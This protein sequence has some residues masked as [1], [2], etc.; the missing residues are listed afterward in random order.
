MYVESPPSFA[1]SAL[2]EEAWTKF[3]QQ[4]PALMSWLQRVGQYY[5]YWT[6]VKRRA[7]KGGLSESDAWML[8][9]IVRQ[10][11]LRKLKLSD[12]PSFTFSFQ[13][14][15]STLEKLHRFDLYLGGMLRSDSLIP[16]EDKNRY[17]VSSIMEEAIASSQLEGASTTREVAKEMLRK[18]RPPR[19]KSEQMILNN[20]RTIQFV[21]AR[22]QAPM[23]PELL[24]Q[25][26]EQ[27]T[28]GTLRDEAHAGHIRLT[29][30]V[31]VWNEVAGE[32]VY[33]PPPATQLPELLKVFCTFANEELASSSNQA[34]L[35]IHPIVRA[36]ILHFLIGYIHPFIDGNGRTARAVF[37]WYLLRQGYWLVEYMSISRIIHESAIQYAKAY[38]HTENDAN[39]LTYFINY[40]VKT[41]NQAFDS[42]QQYIGRKMA[43]KKQLYDFKRLGV[44][45]ERQLVIV[46]EL[47]KNPETPWTFREVEN[48]FSVAYQ[49]ARTDLIGLEDLKLL[50]K[51]RV[52]KQKLLYFRAEDFDQRLNQLRSHPV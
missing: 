2:S 32:V 3:L 22:K 11:S 26:Q 51:R 5:P 35:F 27:M 34:G 17:L 7:K 1:L 45:N 20:Y 40:Q 28:Q 46:Q 41:L 13:I 9:K 47:A 6:E 30:S 49:T 14:T 12:I 38:L 15:E 31:E 36:C 4:E 16:A 25:I 37:Y 43:E 50:E 52:G 39:D 33:V 8:I 10:T 29:D 48:R 24:C 44:L 19:T 21:Q 18:Q 42:L 23:T